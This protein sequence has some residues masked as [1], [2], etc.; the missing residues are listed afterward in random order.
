MTLPRALRVVSSPARTVDGVRAELTVHAGAGADIVEVR[1]DRL[2]ISERAG[3]DRLFPTPV[4]LLGTLRSRAEGGEGPDDPSERHRWLTAMCAAPFELIDLEVRRDRASGLPSAPSGEPRRWVR[5]MHLAGVREWDDAT[6]VMAET[7]PA[8]AW[9][10]IVVPATMDELVNRILPAVP[11]A[12]MSRYCV[13]TTG[14]SGSILRAWA[15]RLGMAAVYCAPSANGADYRPD[16]AVEA[17][18]IPIDRLRPEAMDADGP[19]FALLGRP[20]AH[21]QSPAIHSRWMRHARRKGVYVVADIASENELSLAVPALIRGGFRGFNV[22]SPWKEAALGLATTASAEATRIGCANT[23]TVDGTGVTAANT[24]QGAVVRR[25]RELRAEGRWTDD[26][27]LVLG[28]GG[29]ARAVLDAARELGADRWV[30]GR[31]RATTERVAQGFGARVW[32]QE[33]SPSFS[34]VFHATTVGRGRGATLEFA[35]A[36]ALTRGSHLIDLVYAP[37]DPALETTARAAGATY[38]AGERLLRYQA[39]GSYRLWWGDGPPGEAASV[40]PDR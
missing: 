34:I 1:V 20:T 22:T 39:A 13:H 26:R 21:S 31:D 23:L 16:A 18:Q 2:P 27:L 19:F 24:D 33:S 4:P 36:G 12:G 29:A 5:S 28:T 7:P 11:P 6:C 25:L 30:I 10:K 15:D 14:A 3:L 37:D 8:T 17:S 38:E 40:G 9:T 32:G 35:I